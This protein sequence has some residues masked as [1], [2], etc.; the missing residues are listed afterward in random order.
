M[1]LSQVGLQQFLQQLLQK[2]QQQ[3]QQPPMQQSMLQPPQMGQAPQQGQ[4]DGSG[5]LGQASSYMTG[6]PWLGQASAGSSM[7]ALASLA[8]FLFI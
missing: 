7:G 3:A 6:L 2:Q 1:D 5:M 8:K 4:S